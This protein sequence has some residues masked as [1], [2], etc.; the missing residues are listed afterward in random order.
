MAH[1]LIV[2][3]NVNVPLTEGQWK[4]G[5]LSAVYSG[6]VLTV[7][8]EVA[9]K[10]ISYYPGAFHVHLV[11]DQKPVKVKAEPTEDTKLVVGLQVDSAKLAETSEDEVVLPLESDAHHSKV[12]AYVLDLEEANPVDLARIKAVKT[13]FPNYASVV[14][15]CDRILE[16]NGAI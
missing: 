6:D 2:I 10:L 9:Q 8:D 12:K 15:E 7:E 5:E 4:P 11:T 16:A 3:S 13:R 14:A 1:T